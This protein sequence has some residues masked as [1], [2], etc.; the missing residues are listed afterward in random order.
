MARPRK[1]GLD[2]FP[3]DVDFFSNRKI[4]ILKA[5]FGADGITIYLYLLCEIYK[6][7]YYL[8]VDDDF[9]YIVADDLNMSQN[10]IGQVIHFLLERSLFDNILFQSDKVL[11]SVSIQ[12]QYQE[13][14]K[15]RASKNPIQVKRFWL[16]DEAETE[17]FIKVVQND[18]F[19]EKN[20]SYSENNDFNSKNND[21]KESKEKKNKINKSKVID[22]PKLF[23]EF[24]MAYPRKASRMLAEQ[25][26]IEVLSD[27]DWL[28]ESQLLE[29]AKNY[30]EYCK[31]LIKEE[32]YIKYASNWLKDSIWMDYLPQNYKKPKK[33]ENSGSIQ[34]NRF[35]N[36]VSKEHDYEELERQLLGSQ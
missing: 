21:T 32:I 13:S 33:K 30:A 12:K 10:K 17:T 4:K 34:N 36:I 8:Q 24:W 6:K 5:Q 26:Y 28:E 20:P 29:A 3:L 9:Y 25:A 31:I 1:E 15:A 11:T 7:G 14:V 27:T 22:P 23:E 16:L 19:S 2:Y 35:N 18:N